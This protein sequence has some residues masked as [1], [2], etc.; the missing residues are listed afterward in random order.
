MTS[1]RRPPL[2]QPAP[3]HFL[4]FLPLPHG[5]IDATS[6]CRTEDVDQEVVGVEAGALV[7]RT[8]SLRIGA[9]VEQRARGREEAGAL[10]RSGRILERQGEGLGV[11]EG[12]DEL[13][14][15]W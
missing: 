15:K 9:G 7:E 2:A 8:E 4:A 1:E 13:L 10:L 6:A 5:G 11:C 14:G 12:G 3:Q